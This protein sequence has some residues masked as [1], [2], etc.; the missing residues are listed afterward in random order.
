MVGAGDPEELILR[1]SLPW[2][3]VPKSRKKS[4]SR[5]DCD[6]AQ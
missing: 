1:D 4:E 5:K 2:D 6:F 3:L